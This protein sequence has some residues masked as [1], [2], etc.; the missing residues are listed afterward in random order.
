MDEDQKKRIREFS[1]RKVALNKEKLG[2]LT[3]DEACEYFENTQ[4]L[5][6]DLIDLDYENKLTSQEIQDID[7]QGITFIN[8]HL[9]LLENYDIGQDNSKVRH[10][11]ITENIKNFYNTFA[12]T[13]RPAL[14]FLR[15]EAGLEDKNAQEL[16]ST[17][18][19]FLAAKK[20]YEKLA[21][22][23]KEQRE[24]I[25]SKKAA[26]E[27]GRGEIASTILAKHFDNQI[28]ICEK[29][30]DKWLKQRDRFF[31]V[32][33]IVIVIN[34]VWYIFI[35]KEIF[36]LQY[37]IMKLAMLSVLSY[38]LSFCSKNYKIE[39]NLKSVNMHRKNVA[40]T[41]DDFLA[42]NPD[43][44]TKSQM[45]K[46]GTEAMFKHLPI[47]YIANEDIPDSGPVNEII[48]K[49]VESAKK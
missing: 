18:K 5:F 49:M 24:E 25:E 15:Q 34:F 13:Y 41:L 21:K 23:L 47:G 22:E 42:A 48:Y 8:N 28:S 14:V 31:Y 44:D 32:I 3:F 46:Q 37:G 38:G 43:I 11:Q 17:Q 26:I 36:T 6:V 10:N 45:I 33:L 1:V 7:S 27:S 30:A 2:S 29:S 39:S 19:D 12:K 16:E 9:N 20:E 4:K 40:Q 35:N